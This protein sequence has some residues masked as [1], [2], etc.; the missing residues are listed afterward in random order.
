MSRFMFL[1][2]FDN[3]GTYRLLHYL[4]TSYNTVNIHKPSQVAGDKNACYKK[5]FQSGQYF[6]LIH[7]FI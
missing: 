7:T 6:I 3:T 1:H 2:C 5:N 4:A